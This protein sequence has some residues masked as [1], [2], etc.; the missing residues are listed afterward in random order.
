MGAI[1]CGLM[2]RFRSL[3]QGALLGAAILLLVHTGI[4][5]TN[6]AH[7]LA[8]LQRVPTNAFAMSIRAARNDYIPTNTIAFR[9][10]ALSV[11]LTQAN[12]LNQQWKLGLPYPVSSDHVTFFYAHPKVLGI[13]GG[14]RIND[15][16]YFGF[17]DGGFSAFSDAE[18][19]WERIQGDRAQ[20]TR[21]AGFQ[22][23]LS[24]G[25]ALRVAEGAL[26]T[27]R[28]QKWRSPVPPEPEISQFDYEDEKGKIRR[29]PFYR[30]EWKR[31][32]KAQFGTLIEMEVSGVTSNIVWY[33][34]YIAGS[35]IL[36]TNYHQMLGV[37]PR[38]HEWGKQFG[39]DPLDTDEFRHYARQVAVDEVNRL[40]KIWDLE[41]KPL[42]T[43]DI[44]WF[45][46]QPRTN[47][48]DLS[49]R[50]GE[51]FYIQIL[52]GRIQLFMDKEHNIEALGR[53]EAIGAVLQNPHRLT[54]GAATQ[55]ARAALE[56]L[57]VPAET[58]A[59][60]PPPTV[61]QCTVGPGERKIALPLYDVFWP[62][63]EAEQKAAQKK[64]GE[65]TSAFGFQVSALR[66]KVVMYASHSPA[67]PLIPLPEDY[68]ELLGLRPKSSANSA[69]DRGRLVCRHLQQ[70][71]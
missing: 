37:S 45:I 27:L 32:K 17:D 24:K 57:G 66:K 62:F 15:R 42:T 16:F 65:G 43:N 31:N 38:R 47:N 56:R 70:L 44:Q 58:L 54:Q 40:V 46:S 67:A 23:E 39:Y 33:Q 3:K 36:P 22:N 19:R 49:A 55:I 1:N 20:R 2:T 7:R 51:R 61:T 63:P 9:E 25:A 4:A 41:A 29:V 26:N 48:F 68:S 35:S 50:V 64:Y 28:R 13:E 6:E 8:L 12:F 5:Y 59:R 30:V 14:I 60:H 52:Q 11:M 18:Q 34:S 53:D 21:L 10:Y 69:H 71:K